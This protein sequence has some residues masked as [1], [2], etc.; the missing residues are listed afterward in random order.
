MNALG[1][2]IGDLDKDGNADLVVAGKTNLEEIGGVYGIF[3]FFGDGTGKWTS[4]LDTG[5]PNNGRERTWG[6]AL[7][8]IDN[9]GV[10]DV[11]AA[12]GDV[13]SPTWRSGPKVKENVPQAFKKGFGSLKAGMTEEEVEKAVGEEVPTHGAF[14]GLVEDEYEVTMYEQFKLRFENKTFGSDILLSTQGP[15]KKGSPERGHF[16]AIEA[17][18][19]QLA[20]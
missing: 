8:D 11:A 17:W 2:A 10:L 16:G 12:F 4:R 5:L 7:T 9:D 13:L 20:R 15:E 6:V 14:A 3:P 18:R 1:V 19:G